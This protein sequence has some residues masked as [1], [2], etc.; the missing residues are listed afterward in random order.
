MVIRKDAGWSTNPNATS[1]A[2]HVDEP[3]R[4][5]RAMSLYAELKR[6]NVFR[7]AAA[8]IVLGWLLLQVSSIVLQFLGVPPWVGKTII[9][10]L[11]IGFI[12]SLAIAWVFEVGPDGVH[13]DDGTT[14][15]AN[16]Q[17]ARRLDILTIIGVVIVAVIA[18]AEQ[19]RVPP[20]AAP[21]PT[22]ATAASAPAPPVE[23]PQR[24]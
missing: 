16:G 1:T 17:H 14:P 24:P 10:L 6:R 18:L 2:G 5:E 15:V 8:Y 19:L 11:V 3:V 21:A 12:P 4:R 20:E 7:V 13:R 9:A 22:V 23:E